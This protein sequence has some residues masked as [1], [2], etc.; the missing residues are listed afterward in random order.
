MIDSH[1]PVAAVGALIALLFMAVVCMGAPGSAARGVL[2][3]T[4]REPDR[5]APLPCRAWVDAAGQ[6]LYEPRT[7]GCTPYRADRSFSCGGMFAMEVP[8]GP[9]V[10]HVERGKEYR[11]VDQRVDVK[12]DGETAIEIRL[13]RW[14]HMRVEGWYSADMHVHFGATDERVLRQLTRADDVN[15]VPALTYWN[16]FDEDWPAWPDGPN[17]AVGDGYLITRRNEEIERIG[18]P[19]YRSVGALLISG[20]ARPI[21]VR[22]HDHTSPCDAVLAGLAKKTTPHCIIDADKPIWG[23]NVVTA[24]LGLFDVVQLCHNHYHR[25]R[26]IGPGWGMAGTE[27]EETP[28]RL[29][30][31]ELFVRTNEVYYRWLNCGLRLAVSG[32]SAMGVM[33]VPLGYNRTYVK[34]DGPLTEESFLAAIRAGRTFATSG[35]MLTLTADDQEVG[36]TIRRRGDD[37]TPVQLRAVLRSIDR[38]AA[39]EIVHNGRIERSVDLSAIAPE[40]MLTRELA[41]DLRPRQSGWVAARALFTAPDGRLREAH[42]SPVYIVVDDKPTASKRDAEYMIRWID[43]LIVLAGEPERYVDEA[44]RQQAL[45]HFRKAHQWYEQV[46]ATAA[47]VWGD[48]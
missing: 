20:L 3:V 42:T 7:P 15:V 25:E 13:S 30:D 11:P 29:G 12:A 26:T 39:L 9:A 47:T 21:F 28:D 24:A 19:P 34:L 32:G 38:I 23:E 48:R 41:V 4:V 44:S 17:V 5:D 36:A 46:A 31:D 14:V 45:E 1:F 43:R 2:T 22:R 18:G 27:I 40:P 8:A 6:R 35:P 33:P 10:V 37:P 16:D